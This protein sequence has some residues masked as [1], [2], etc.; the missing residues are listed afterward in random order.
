[1]KDIENK[2]NLIERRL[3]ALIEGSSSK[4]FQSKDRFTLLNKNLIYALKESEKREV[5]G[6]IFAADNFVVRVNPGQVAEWLSDQRT[7]ESTAIYLRQYARE[8]G[9]Q[10]ESTPMIKVEPDP[11]VAPGDIRIDLN[12]RGDNITRTTAISIDE[13]QSETEIPSDAYLIVDGT[14]IFTCDQPNIKIGRYPENQLVINDRRVSRQ[15]AQIRAIN[16]NFV[17]FDLNSSGGTF[18]NG[19]RINQRVLNPGDVISL[20]GVPLVYGQ[21]KPAQENT[22]HIT[23]DF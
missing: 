6:E 10:F 8:E 4:L 13:E 1:M 3:Q 23:I 5:N 11:D 17:L 21:E 9:I 15:H 14:E 12:F 7:L 20:A 19:D 16:G 18:V 2:L 22:Q